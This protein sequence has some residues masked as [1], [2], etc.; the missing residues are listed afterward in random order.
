MIDDLLSLTSLSLSDP[1]QRVDVRNAVE[2]AVSNLRLAIS[3]SG[4][5]V[6]IGALPA[7]WGNESHLIELFQNLIDNA[8]K[9]RSE[10]RVE[11]DVSAEPSAGEWLVKVADNGIGIA[12]EHH[13]RIFGLFKRLGAREV[14]GTGI[15]LAL[16][17]KIVEELGGKI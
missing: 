5:R 16:C 15:G 1:P 3:E 17:K 10:A 4:A 11:I 2:A 6:T 14:P 9:Y 12:P 8:I 13:D 7:A